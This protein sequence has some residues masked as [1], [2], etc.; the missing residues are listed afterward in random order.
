MLTP[1]LPSFIKLAK[2]KEFE[3]KPMYYN[4]AKEE[5]KKRYEKIKKEIQ[6]A[7]N[8]PNTH[9]TEIFRDKLRERWG[10]KTYGK[11]V[12]NFNFRVIIIIFLIVLGLWYIFK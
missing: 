4:E 11:S 6:N 2:Y 3:Y 10:R 7:E 5:M 8:N 1:K 12:S 9:S